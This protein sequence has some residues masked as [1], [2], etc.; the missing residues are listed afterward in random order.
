MF[1]DHITS[2]GLYRECAGMVC[3]TRLHVPNMKRAKRKPRRNERGK[4]SFPGPYIDARDANTEP[5]E[6]VVRR[7]RAVVGNIAHTAHMADLMLSWRESSV[8]RTLCCDLQDVRRCALSCTSI[9]STMLQLTL[10]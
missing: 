2:T 6:R 5:P 9:L 3:V 8:L 1:T 10:C 4:E 7:E